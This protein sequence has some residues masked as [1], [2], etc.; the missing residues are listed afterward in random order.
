MKTL[1][2]TGHRP[3][4]LPWKYKKEGP[5]Y[6]EYCESLGCYIDD[7]IRHG[8]THFISGMAL[9]VDMDFAETV[10]GFKVHYGLDISLE[11]AIPCPNQTLKWSPAETAR[12]KEILEKADKVTM[13]TDHFF[14][15]CML[16]RNDYM[17]DHS[18]LVLAIWN[19]EQS[20]GTWHTI[21]Y[22][23]AKGKKVDIINIGRK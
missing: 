17:V 7:C 10:L 11:C 13:V 6:D 20:G 19:G 8:Y 2:V 21:Q 23:K 9:G 15:A 5:E 12:Y 22:A 4:K 16:V 3:A 14:R 1:C 18:D